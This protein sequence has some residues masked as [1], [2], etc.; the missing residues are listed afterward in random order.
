MADVSSLVYIGIDPD[1]GSPSSLAAYGFGD[2]ISETIGGTGRDNL[3]GLITTVGN[4]PVTYNTTTRQFTVE[5]VSGVSATVDFEA[6]R[7]A[8]AQASAPVSFNGQNIIQVNDLSA[9]GNLVL[10]GISNGRVLAISGTNGLV[11][12]RN[13]VTGSILPVTA[14]G[15][16]PA[17]NHGSI[18]TYDDNTLNAYVAS[19]YVTL[20][21]DGGISMTNGVGLSIADGYLVVGAGGY[22]TVS[23]PAN[24]SSLNVTGNANVSGNL[25]AATYL[26][27]RPVVSAVD[28]ATTTTVNIGGD[29]DLYLVNTTTTSVTL[30]L[31][32][33][34]AWNNKR[35]TVSKV[36]DGGSYRSVTLSGATLQTATN[37]V[38][39]YDPTESVTVISN[40]TNW[41]SLDYDR[42]Y[43]VVFVCKNST[44]STLTKGTPVRISGATGANVLI[45]AASA[46]NNHVPKAP[47]GQLSKCIGVVEHDIPTGEFGHVLTKGVIYKYNTDAFNEGDQLYLAASGGFTNVRPSAPYDEVFLGIVTRKNV[48]NGTILVDIENPLHINDIA[49]VNLASSLIHG[50][51][52]QYDLGTSTFVNTQ[53]I[54]IS[55]TIKAGSLSA[56][57]YLNLPSSTAIWNA[58]KLQGSSISSGTAANGDA[59]IWDSAAA[60]WTFSPSSGFG[61]PVGA[62][63]LTLGLNTRLTAERVLTPGTG[64]SVTDNGA[65]STYDIAA[66]YTNPIW[67]AGNMFQKTI[68]TATA[69]L[70]NGDLIYYN[71]IDEWWTV[72]PSSTIAG[73]GGAPTDAQYLTLATNGS[74]SAER[75]LTAGDGLGSNDGGANGNFTISLAI[76]A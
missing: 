6:V 72:T 5:A 33:A 20:P 13:L 71:A 64:L 18:L 75:V 69:P 9:S 8:L 2:V 44:G 28:S 11:V 56:T 54:D 47:D 67:Y 17:R 42:A 38:L 35:I 51:L 52:I 3:S 65:N 16:E 19:Q 1:T 76:L 59:L 37:T 32:D 12:G 27:I 46:A 24:V 31:P 45:S 25:S 68:D 29:Y 39:L 10:E 15:F 74:L 66:D 41:Y 36:D 22:A 58:N 57:T 60:Q 30:Y 21:Y 48:N 70:N 55:G 23:G 34:S 49:G 4:V 50:D 43:G 73:G 7:T 14:V 62:S 61:A 26:N 63:Y 53:S 40:G